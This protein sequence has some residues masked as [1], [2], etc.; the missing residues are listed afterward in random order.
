MMTSMSGN[1]AVVG[2]FRR[3]VR[4]LP[5]MCGFEAIT[6]EL[7]LSVTLARSRAV[8]PAAVTP[9]TVG[10]V[11]VSESSTSS[12]VGVSTVVHPRT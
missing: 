11:G 1:V 6:T 12:M 3:R 2:A 9:V 7:T 8:T 4:V 5:Q 10:A